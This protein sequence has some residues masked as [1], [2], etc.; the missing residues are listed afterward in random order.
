[1]TLTATAF[2]FIIDILEK[3]RI[4]Y[5]ISGG[6]AARAYGSTRELADIDIDV[7]DECL[8]IIAK[9][10]E[11]YIVFGP[12]RY[13]DENWNLNLITLNYHGQ[14]IDI[15]G[16]SAQIYNQQTGSWEEH[17]SD[18]AVFEWKELFGR[19]VP[20]ES[21]Q[22]LIN[23]KTKLGRPVDIEDVRQ[24]TTRDMLEL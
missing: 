1:M 7:P 6:L 22:C 12:A 16:N 11:H 9:E 24:L 5:K 21:K 8:P 20:V 13:Q 17:A 23:Y 18:L 10:V 15:S 3:H 4:P 14:D 2:H 19:R